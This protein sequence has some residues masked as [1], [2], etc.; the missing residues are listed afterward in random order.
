MI[1]NDRRWYRIPLIW[2]PI[3]VNALSNIFNN[4][5]MVN[6][7]K[8]DENCSNIVTSIGIPSKSTRKFSHFYQDMTLNV[9][10]LYKI[11]GIYC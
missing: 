2:T 1:R 7:R 6:D 3:P 10:V 5:M 4:L 8:M 11:V 9:P